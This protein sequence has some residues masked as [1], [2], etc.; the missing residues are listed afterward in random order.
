MW[1]TCSRSNGRRDLTVQ[2]QRSFLLIGNS[3]WH[4][5][6]KKADSWHFFHT[7][8]DLQI[9]NTLDNPLS[10]WA[11]VGPIPKR[12]LMNN[13]KRIEINDVPLQKSPTWLGVD[14]ALA[15][16]GAFKKAKSSNTHS[17]GI[18]VADAGTVMSLTRITAKGEFAGGQ[19]IPGL[20]LQLSA[21]AYGTQNLNDPGSPSTSTK[22]FPINTAEAMRRGC[23]QALVGAII[24]A[25]KETNMPIWLCGGDAPVL[26]QELRKR[27]T[28]AV[29]HPNLVLEGMVDIENSINQSQD[30]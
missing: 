30:H 18:L 1:D 6:I 15:G 7:L 28:H 11:A 27:N 29:H 4:W 22:Q 25:Q 14:R 26:M 16:W 17:S 20:R 10:A 21:M 3:R 19:L 13:S 8:P 2:G 5:A 9:I 23:L 12:L 24:L